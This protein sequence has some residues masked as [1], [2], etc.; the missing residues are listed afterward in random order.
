V[1][2]VCVA[3]MIIVSGPSINCMDYA[4]CYILHAE[5]D[6]V[7][8]DD[9]PAVDGTPTRAS[10]IHNAC[11]TSGT[12][13][14][15]SDNARC[16]T[17]CAPGACCFEPNLECAKVDCITYAE[18]NILY[19]SLVSVTRAEV[20]DACK[21]HR[22]VSNGQPTLCEQICTLQ[23]MQC[24]FHQNNDESCDDTTQSPGSAYCNNYAA[25][26]VL[27]TSGTDIRDAHQEEL[28]TA[29]SSAQLR[30]KCI[31]LCAA[32]TCCYSTSLAESCANVDASITC[33]EYSACDVLYAN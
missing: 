9:A 14:A 20:E 21:N 25:C 27:G 31:S 32:A 4:G 1:H 19:P 18:C 15:A 11:F 30:A 33:E 12:V 8:D 26:E 2:P 13:T 6:P 17:L 23:V 7:E 29:C 10:E 5:Q 22:D 28:E 24:C 16:K 3:L